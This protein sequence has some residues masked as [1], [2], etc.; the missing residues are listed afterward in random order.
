MSA[1]RG[2][3]ASGDRWRQESKARPGGLVQNT[4]G[5]GQLA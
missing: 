1:D 5:D 4:T 3:R 2:R